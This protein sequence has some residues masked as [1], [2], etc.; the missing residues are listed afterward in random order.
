MC[1]TF[2]V[3]NENLKRII[4]Q[5]VQLIQG[6]NLKQAPIQIAV[7]SFTIILDKS[8]IKRDK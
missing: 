6:V 3:K 1:Q 5:I 4:N 7:R 2:G 8:E